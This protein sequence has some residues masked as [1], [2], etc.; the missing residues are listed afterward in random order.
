MYSCQCQL[1]FT[2]DM[3]ADESSR[4]ILSLPRAYAKATQ[5]LIEAKKWDI[6]QRSSQSLDPNPIKQL[7]IY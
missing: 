3:T 2:D 7:F 1:A 6:L 5:E 4:A